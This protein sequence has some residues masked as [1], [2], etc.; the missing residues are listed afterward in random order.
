MGAACGFQHAS[1]PFP[2]TAKGYHSRI[3]PP[4]RSDHPFLA[5]LG[6]ASLAAALALASGCGTAD[7]VDSITSVSIT[8]ASDNSVSVPTT[9]TPATSAPITAPITAP[10]TTTAPTTTAATEPSPTRQLE[11]PIPTGAFEIDAT[12][13]FVL[14]RSG[15]LEVWS[16]ALTSAPGQRTLV[17]DYPDPFGVVT[18]GPGPNVIDDVAGEIGGTVVFGDCCEP[19]SGTVLAATGPGEVMRISGG[20]SP[21]LSPTGDLLGTANDNGISQTATDST[22]AGTFR[23]LNQSRQAYLNVTDLAWSSNGTGPADDDHMVLL[24]WDVDGWWLYDI[25]RSTLEPSPAVLL[26]PPPVG[27]D[28]FTSMEF[29]GHGPGGEIVVT[30]GTAA[31]TRLRHFDPTTLAERPQLERSLP[32]SARSIRLGDDGLELLWVDAGSLYH[33]PAGDLEADRLGTDVLAAWFVR[34]VAT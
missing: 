29:A 25:D 22:G 4:T 2:A 1:M 34:S 21:T 28:P 30:E 8:S 17:A 5:A 10:A 19:I 20:Y 13:V 3:V 26:G 12:D 23:Q 6:A 18:E 7:D 11:F 9:V 27:Q 33:L 24:A 15:D 31:T 14:S 32:G 16:A